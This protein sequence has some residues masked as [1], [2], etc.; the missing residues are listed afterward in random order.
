MLTLTIRVIANLLISER[1]MKNKKKRAFQDFINWVYQRWQKDLRMHIYHYANYEIAA[2]R[3]IMGRYSVCEYEVEQLL[4]NEVFID[5]YKIFKD[6]IL[7]GEP[8]YSIKNVEHL[9][10]HKRKTKVSNG[11][12]SILAYELW[13]TLN[14][15]GEQ[16][17]TWQTSK[18]LNVIRD[19]NIDDCESTQELVNWLR[20]Q[21][22]E[23]G[24]GYLDKIEITEPDVKKE[25]TERILLRERLLTRSLSELETNPKQSALTQNLAWVLEFH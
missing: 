24:I 3:R 18:I 23:L 17:D 8:R 4:R 11:G 16:G 19:Y 1:T 6:S 13:R 9:Y 12:D 10:R 2:C 22:V 14:K 5:L 15:Q 21:Q 7:L 20:R 25:T